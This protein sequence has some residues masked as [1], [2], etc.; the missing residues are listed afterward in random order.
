MPSGAIT[1]PSRMVKPAI[2]TGLPLIT[3]TRSTLFPL[4][5]ITD[6]PGPNIEIEF[7][8]VIELLSTIG[9]LRLTANTM[10]SPGL[11]IPTMSRNVPGPLLLS[12]VTV[13]VAPAMYAAEQ[14]YRDSRIARARRSRRLLRRGTFRGKAVRASWTGGAL[15]LLRIAHAI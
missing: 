3:N 14:R 4:T 12:D 8:I 15:T 7:P 13:S 2:S 9:P 11:L 10:I 1:L 6:G 5:A